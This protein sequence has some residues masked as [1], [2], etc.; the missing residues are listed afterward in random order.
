[1]P[2]GVMP[3]QFN[4]YPPNSYPVMPPM[5]NSETQPIDEDENLC[6]CVLSAIVEDLKLTVSR[7]LNR[8]VVETMAF[9]VWWMLFGVIVIISNFCPVFKVY[10]SWWD[11]NAN[12]MSSS[13]TT[14]VGLIADKLTAI[15]EKPDAPP[16]N[17]P[18]PEKPD[19]K[20]KNQSL[21]NAFD[22]LN[23]AKNSFEMDGFRIGLGLRSAVLKMP[24][25]RV[26]KRP[27]IPSP[28]K[29]DESEDVMLT[30]KARLATGKENQ[31]MNLLL[32]H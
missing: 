4:F 24:S 17:Q 8:K 30:K 12:A 18:P 16:N 15:N 11:E 31:G 6:Q 23:W 14:S 25:F 9:K 1:M 26:K 5:M 2:P 32:C 21:L 27:I 3:P 22:P 20:P 13:K 19:S 29:D 28:V 7:D 10:E